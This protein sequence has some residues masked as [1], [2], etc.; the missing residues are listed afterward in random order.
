MSLYSQY[1]DI[2]EAQ[3]VFAKCLDAIRYVPLLV[4]AAVLSFFALF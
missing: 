3:E 2:P 1:E 4:V